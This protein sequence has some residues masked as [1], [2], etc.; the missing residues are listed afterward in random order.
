M[1]AGVKGTSDYA[2]L[3]SENDSLKGVNAEGTGY[4]TS[5]KSPL[6]TDPYDLQ[7]SLL[8]SEEENTPSCLGKLRN[9]FC[10]A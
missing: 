6:P 7:A 1:S 4:Q 10:K 8:A 3:P 5:S 2:A 9:F